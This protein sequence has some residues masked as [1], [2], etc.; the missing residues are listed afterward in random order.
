MKVAVLGIGSPHGDDQIGW[1]LLDELQKTTAHPDIHW[2]KVSAPVTSL[3]NQLSAFDHIL[4]I[5]AADI[6]LAPGEYVFLEDAE[7]ALDQKETVVSSHSMGLLESWKMAKALKM[8][9]PR[10]S[11]FLVQLEQCEP[12]QA[13]SPSLQNKFPD[14]LEKVTCLFL[15]NKTERFSV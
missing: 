13:I 9:L 1:L 14:M 12:M 10:V 15:D 5:D 6:G 4:A 2:E 7:N 11:L 8:K 3:V